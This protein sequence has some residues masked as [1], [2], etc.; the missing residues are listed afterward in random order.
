MN[1]F[2]PYGYRLGLA[3]AI[4]GS[5]ALAL[6]QVPSVNRPDISFDQRLGAKLPLDASFMDEEGKKV[7]L[8]D[9]FGRRPVVLAFVFYRCNGTCLLIRDGILR[10]LN[11]QKK[12]IAGRDFDV[13]AIS[14]DPRETPELAKAKKTSWLADYKY[15]GTESGWHF[16]TGTEANT[17]AVA[18]QVGFKYQINEKT[19]QISHPSGIIV[20]T[21]DGHASEYQIGVTFPQREVMESILRAKDNVIGQKTEETL[22]GCIQID[23]KTG[24]MRIKVERVLQ[25][26]GIAT[27]AGL[28]ASIVFM[29]RK[30]RHPS[31]TNSDHRSEQE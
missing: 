13:V 15:K 31:T 2:R 11:A 22:L 3:C 9:Y 8:G 28:L 5:S 25:I 10:T 16:L 27:L 21:E 7:A 19:D 23:P 18:N 1:V 17:R 12:L 4:L 30:Y 6:P 29:S 14:I 26:L 20:C 24:A